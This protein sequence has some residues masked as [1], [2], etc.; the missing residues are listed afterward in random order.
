MRYLL[1]MSV[2]IPQLHA[3]SISLFDGKTLANWEVPVG[4]EKWWQVKDGMIVGGSL[5][6]RVPKNLFLPSS[7]E[8]QN[9][10]LS[11]KIRLVAGA[12]FMNSGVQVRSKREG[13]AA[14]M[15][16]YQVDAGIGYW[17]DLYDE[18]RRNRKLAG[19]GNPSALAAA[20]KDWEWNEYRILAE[21]R[22]IR[23]WINGCLSFDFTEPD[24]SI[25]LTGRLG[26][27]VHSGG[28][29]LV[30]VKELS[31]EELPVTPGAPTWDAI[32]PAPPVPKAVGSSAKTPEDERHLFRL[33]E[34]FVAELVASE[35]QGVGKP[36]SMAWDARGRL[37]TMSALE[38]PMDAN[39]DRVNAEALYARGGA[40]RVLVFDEPEKPGPHTP[41]VFVDGLALP[42]GILP[43]LDGHGVMVQYGSQIRRYLDVDQDGKAD[44]H[45]VILDGFGIQ[46]SHLMPHQFER[47][48]GSWIYLAQ[49]LFNSSTVRRPGALPFSDGATQK[50]FVAC[51]LAR[52]RPDGSDFEIVTAGPNNIWGLLQ[53]RTGETFLQEANDMGIPV[54]EFEPGA[55][56]RT[57]SKDRLRPYAPQMPASLTKGLGGSGLSGLAIAEDAGSPFAK[58]Y[59]GDE[60]IFVANPITSRIQV[61]T[62]DRATN[63]HPQYF[64]REDFL[65]S[66]DPWFRPVSIHF[67]PDGFLYIADWYNKIISHNEVPRAHP[68]RDKTRGRIWRI[69]PVN[70]TMPARLDLTQLSDSEVIGLL[71]GASARTAAMAWAW[72]GERMNQQTE[73]ALAGILTDRGASLERRLD[74]LRAL[75][76]GEALGKEVL[77]ALA[78]DSA[79]EM[80]YQALRA[81]GEVQLPADDFVRIFHSA[82]DDPNYRVR[83][84]LANSVRGHRMPSVEMLALVAK[85][86]RA[87]LQSSGVWETYDRDF[88]RY[89]ARWALELHREGTQKLLENS[90]LVDPENRMLAILSL[91]AARAATLLVRELPN[92]PRALSADELSVLGS[93]LGQ[94][95]VLAAFQE[96]LGDET[97]RTSVLM[98]LTQLDSKQLAN[99]ALAAA[100]SDACSKLLGGAVTKADQVLILKLARLLRLSDLEPAISKWMDP[101]RPAAELVN[102]L[103]ALRE[104]GSARV[105]LFSAYLDHA[106][107]AVRREAIAALAF[108]SDVQSIERLSQRWENLPA[109][110]RM[111]VVDG[112][113]SSKTKAGLF[114]KAASEGEFEGLDPAALEKLQAV[115]GAEDPSLLALMKQ[116]GVTLGS[117]IRLQGSGGLVM[118]HPIDLLGAFTVETWIMLDPG[119]DNGDGL[120]GKKGGPD[121]NFY[122]R[123]LH[124][125]G[126]PELGNLLISKC[127]FTAGVWYH[128]AVTRDLAGSFRIY[129]NGELD[130]QG[131]RTMAEPLRGLRIGATSSGKPGAA[132]YDEFR[133]WNV[134]RSASEVRDHFRTRFGRDKPSQLLQRVAADS[135]GPWVGTSVVELTS[136]FPTLLSKEQ[137][138]SAARRFS[139][140][141]E[142]AGR[143]GNADAGRSL[144]RAACMICHQ[145]KGEGTQI[146]PDLSGMA[147][148]GVQGILRNILDPNA[149]LESGY[150]RHDVTCSDGSLVSGFLVEETKQSITIRQIGAD[151]KVILRTS[152]AAHR[153][154]KRSLMPEGLI[155][156]F[157]E[158]QVADMFAYIKSLQ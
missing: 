21:G 34:G 41:R 2:L 131:G 139:H 141:H 68:D 112:L 110:L 36:V 90:S 111:L 75:E 85:L 37:W 17:G 32:P 95:P 24:S 86:G 31:I 121:F 18:H 70:S 103:S 19:A 150:Y 144:F 120:L 84:A 77:E 151:P 157:S 33:P 119:I 20:V 148:M 69:R 106:D 50:P 122:G 52:F 127:N 56:Y 105:E 58:L 26:I 108:C 49:G 48:P 67:G 154:S 12:G 4:D 11:F 8:F 136:D 146:G 99:P 27:Q 135:G 125:Y 64:K 78:G 126:G 62:T 39:E 51:K 25:P 116:L 130:Q 80:R 13:K 152:I 63:Q 10:D 59:G 7:R 97:T 65:V 102:L 128:C 61:I 132:R 104:M 143:P 54:T 47:A 46:D 147:A 101:E 43:D 93:Q 96:L 5:D 113:T 156:G 91:D 42:L 133:I 79:P 117:V 57:G 3:G 38:Y 71:G 44:K 114:A 129:V 30:Q 158:Q 45:D 1:L 83:A 74:A 138:E 118:D 23:S 109:A 92:L 81:A 16:G 124:L 53:T 107:E 73:A 94:A 76:A 40:D 100:V 88:E 82:A 35:E 145:V 89:L 115:L 9:F 134:A 149:Q 6:E 155:E 14:S 29:L 123:R 87:P 60:V 28:S 137:A 153:I 72:L 142:L 66:D 98:N 55:H 140:Y 22:R 15:T